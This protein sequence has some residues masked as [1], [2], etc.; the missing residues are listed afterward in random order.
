M[1]E[2]NGEIPM[3]GDPRVDAALLRIHGKFRDLEDAMLV[4]VHLENRLRARFDA[5]M[6]SQDQAIARHDEWMK[7][8]E[9]KLNALS[10]MLMRR[11]GG[12]EAI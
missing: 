12:P 3:T 2:P 1:P 9:D 10:D 7:H 4:Q 11:E 5:H 8:F 6:D